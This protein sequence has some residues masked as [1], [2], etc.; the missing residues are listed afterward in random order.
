MIHANTQGRLFSLNVSIQSSPVPV[1]S[2][3]F[4]LLKFQFFVYHFQI[5]CSPQIVCTYPQN[6]ASFSFTSA[7]YFL[8]FGWLQCSLQPFYTEIG[9]LRLLC[10]SSVYIYHCSVTI[11]MFSSIFLFLFLLSKYF[12]ST[13]MASSILF[14]PLWNVLSL[15]VC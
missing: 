3:F 6:L 10:F 8:Y 14:I 7:G 5:Q 13:L 4:H 9:F 11:S 2:R 1:F 12:H 15:P